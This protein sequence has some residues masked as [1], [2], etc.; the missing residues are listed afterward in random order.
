MKKFLSVILV[1]TLLVSVV[2]VDVQ[3]ASKP[4]VTKKLSITV[5]SKKTI[6]VK[7]KYIKSKK[8]KTN[9]KSIATVNKK[10]KVTGKKAG[11]AKIIV[12]VKYKKTKKSKKYTT[13]KYT[14]TVTVKDNT[15]VVTEKPQ[16]TQKPVVTNKPVTTPVVTTTPERTQSPVVTPKPTGI[17][18][19]PV[20]PDVP[21]ETPEPVETVEPTITP[22]IS[23]DTGNDEPVI[24]PTPEP[25]ICWHEDGETG[26]YYVGREATTQH[27]GYILPICK[28]CGEIMYYKGELLKD[29]SITFNYKGESYTY[30]KWL[31]KPSETGG[32][33][34][35]IYKGVD[36]SDMTEEEIAKEYEKID[37]VYLD[38][39]TDVFY[40]KTEY[41]DYGDGDI[42]KIYNVYAKSTAQQIGTIEYPSYE[43][44]EID[45]GNGEKTKVYGYYDREIANEMYELL[46]AHR[47]ENGV[48]ELTVF[49]KAQ[50]MSDTRAA[51]FFYTWLYDLNLEED[52]DAYG[53]HTRPDYTPYHSISTQECTLLWENETVVTLVSQEQ[54]GGLVQSIDFNAE[55][56]MERFKESESHNAI[57]LEDN[58]NGVG[59]SVFIGYPQNEDG[60]FKS[61][62]MATVMQDFSY[63]PIP[64]EE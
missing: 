41:I 57:M 56:A 11:K 23:P 44:V 35:G 63:Q 31:T 6:K 33:I 28:T 1:M 60:S 59:I 45:L 48:H 61:Y 7:G 15:P 24:T 64:V 29:P 53:M 62:K 26:V 49:D 22:T 4:T 55:Y 47:V 43:V 20:V 12:T 51:E 9:K 54:A 16:I 13:K 10:G 50:A 30:S 58:V 19:I 27:S 18:D 40:Y 2:P 17:P 25:A 39:T 36:I 8:F 5:G 3:A 37:V 42:R 38:G 34:L 32:G 21:T 46:N 52:T 14:C